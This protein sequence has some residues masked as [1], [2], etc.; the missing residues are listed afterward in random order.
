MRNDRLQKSTG[1]LS[2]DELRTILEVARTGSLSGAAR[3]LNVEH[4]TV[5]RR[6][7][8]AE[9][10]IKLRLFDRTRTGYEARTHAETL[11]EAARVMEEAVLAAE[12]RVLGA[13]ER[14][15]GDIHLG[16][17]EVLGSYLVPQLVKGFLAR[18]P[19]IRIDIGITN[20]SIDLTRREADLALRVTESPPEHLIA[21][22]VGTITY[23][24]YA[25]PGL[26]RGKR[27]KARLAELPWLGFED[28]LFE[29][30]QARWL[31]AHPPRHALRT[32]WGSLISMIHAAE[33]GLGVAAL[34][35]LAAAQHRGLVRVSDVLGEIPLYLL[36]HPDVRGNARARAL[37]QYFAEEAPAMIARLS[38]SPRVRLMRN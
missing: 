25:A 38:E 11:V 37:S 23:A 21:R 29:V 26:L 2:W 12:R 19:A 3:V 24:A 33:A 4:S 16:A 30:T 27:A 34:T 36:T 17:S 1:V 10:R 8:A 7:A 18:H 14:L 35:C 20:R 6:L 22:R 31:R 13:D 5:H 15:T 9:K 28:A 32:R